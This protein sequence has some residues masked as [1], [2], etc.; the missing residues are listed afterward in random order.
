[1]INSAVYAILLNGVLYMD[2][3]GGKRVGAGRPKGA[4]TKS[5]G[6]RKYADLHIWITR[7]AVEYLKAQAAG[8]GISVSRL[9]VEKMVPENER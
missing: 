5:G 8:K 7:R 3:W 4:K 1:M 2:G 9:V 6:E